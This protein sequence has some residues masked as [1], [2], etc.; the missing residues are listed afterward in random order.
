MSKH[1][2]YTID[3]SDAAARLAGS[4]SDEQGWYAGLAAQLVRPDDRLALDVG[5][6]GAGMTAALA[7]LLPADGL[8]VAADHEPAILDA[9]RDRLAS[10][11]PLPATV[12]F[13]VAS[14]DDG[15]AGLRDAAGGPVD[16][17][18]AS[19][20]VHHAGDQQAAVDALAGL[21]APGG[22]LALAEG[23]LRPSYLPWDLGVG[24][25]GLELRLEAA[26]DR[27]FSRMRAQLPGSRPMPYGWTEALRRA[28][29]SEVT[30][31][32]TVLERPVPL[33][34]SDRDRILHRIAHRVDWLRDTDLV[35]PADQATWDRLLD[36]GSEVW[37]GHRADLHA[38]EA[39]SVHIGLR[40]R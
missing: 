37:L 2:P 32:T 14:L 7:A 24:E 26:Q 8:V 4:A 12:R 3:W 29:L 22:R 1:D 39:R 15:V 6:G 11:P 13:A 27:W 21:L 36:S 20:A 23:G 35:D 31:R 30:T 18:W 17:V 5:C 16:I 33:N 28:G 25:P 38:I 34:E 40:R 19:A 9:A 10:G